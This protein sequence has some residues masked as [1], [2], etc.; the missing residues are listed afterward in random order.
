MAEERTAVLFAGQGAQKPGMGK[1]LY[2]HFPECRRIFEEAE[3]IRPGLTELCFEGPQEALNETENTQPCVLTV[4]V[5]A[6]AAFSTLGI[7]PYAGAGFSLGEYAALVAADVLKFGTALR[8]VMQRARW[9][10]EAA[11]ETPGGMAAVL[12]KSAAEVEEM[13]SL[14]RGEGVLQPVNYNC[15]GQIVVAGDTIELDNLIAYARENRVKARKLPVSGAFHSERMHSAAEKTGQLLEKT[16]LSEPSFTLYANRT[17]K[18]YETAAMRSTLSEQTENPV[19]FEHIARDLL[20][21]GV[22]TF[23]E[24]GPGT[25]LI[26]FLKRIDKS[27]RLLNVDGYDSFVATKEALS[28]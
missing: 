26:G 15:P 1:S 23:V 11:D 13:V 28:A 12:G 16:E 27:A 5:A 10:Q 3:E 24:L 21:K 19:L 18:P 4:D 7:R 25:T 22:R 17:A 6:W 9:M 8:I 2:D 14:L 20:K